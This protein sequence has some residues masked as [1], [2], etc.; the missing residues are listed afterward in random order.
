[1]HTGDACHSNAPHTH[2]DNPGPPLQ[3]RTATNTDITASTVAS[4]LYRAALHHQLQSTPRDAMPTGN[5]PRRALLAEA[6]VAGGF[7]LLRLLIVGAIALVHRRVEVE[8][9][10]PGLYIRH[11][12]NAHYDLAAALDDRIDCLVEGKGHRTV[13]GKLARRIV[14]RC[15]RLATMVRMV[16]LDVLF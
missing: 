14:S 10:E 1:M 7:D 4:Y 2:T 11:L 15:R 6:I 12:A 3:P 8:H 9:L 5:L 16:R 13:L